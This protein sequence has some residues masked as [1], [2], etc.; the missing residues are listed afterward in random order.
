M[1]EIMGI[2]TQQM[3]FMNNVGKSVIGSNIHDI[4]MWI[5]SL[6]L[7]RFVKLHDVSTSHVT[8]ASR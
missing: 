6:T 1:L 2:K 5:F 8:K 3:K 7:D 4:E